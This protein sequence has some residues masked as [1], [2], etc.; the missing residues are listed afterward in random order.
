MTAM[1]GA[2]SWKSTRIRMAP[3][4]VT[5]CVC[6]GFTTPGRPGDSRWTCPEC[7][8]AP[9]CGLTGVVDEALAAFFAV[10]ERYTLAD[11]VAQRSAA[12]LD[13]FVSKV[14]IRKIDPVAIGVQT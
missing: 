6:K 12:L 1:S 14:P 13:I 8:I 2:A 5:K 4:G 7:P 9:A 10:L 11:L 3:I